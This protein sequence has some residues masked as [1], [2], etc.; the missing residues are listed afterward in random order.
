MTEASGQWTLGVL[1][2]LPIAVVIVFL[3]LAVAGLM[4][5]YGRTRAS[6]KSSYGWSTRKYMLVWSPIVA[7]VAVIVAA[8]TAFSF[9]PWHAEYHQYR[10]VTGTVEQVSS[11]LISAGDQ[12][13]SNQ[14]FV[15]ILQQRPG[16]P[17]GITD[18]RASL[19]HKGD[20]VHLRCIREYEF[21]S[22]N[23]GYNC[24]WGR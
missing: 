13:G 17:Y 16:T 11:R 20:P 9:W 3:L 5:W 18:T 2:G 24:K 22:N 1:I 19:L 14:K 12:G 10:D 4:Q 7:A 15:V 6:R 21:G 8:I 23:A